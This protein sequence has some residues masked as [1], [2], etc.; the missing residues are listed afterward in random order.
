MKV[1]HEEQFG[2]VVPV[3]TFTEL[4]EIFQYLSESVY[5][6]QA[7]IFGKDTTKIGALVDVLVNCVSRVNINCQCQRVSRFVGSN[8][9]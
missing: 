4:E 8:C 5:G 2:P 6:Q 9:F 7:A 3:T 1:Y